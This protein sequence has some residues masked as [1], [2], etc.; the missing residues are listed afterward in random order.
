M[1][2]NTKPC[3]NNLFIL[4]IFH[5]ILR[6]ITFRRSSGWCWEH[7]NNRSDS[8][9]EKSSGNECYNFNHWTYKLFKVT[10]NVYSVLLCMCFSF[11]LFCI[12]NLYDKAIKH[13]RTYRARE[14]SNL[15][16]QHSYDRF[17]KI[18]HMTWNENTRKWVSCVR[19]VKIEKKRNEIEK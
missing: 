8:K 1:K 4:S 18:F 16:K 3:L 19:C 5:L 11:L 17:K 2:W 15:Q 13:L 9:R 10:Q 6:R 7:R 14:S 12:M